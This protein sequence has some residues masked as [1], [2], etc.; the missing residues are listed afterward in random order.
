MRVELGRMV[1][2]VMMMRM[3]R[4]VFMMIHFH[5]MID[6]SSVQIMKSSD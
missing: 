6:R 2:L 1:C 5:G 4:L 3:R